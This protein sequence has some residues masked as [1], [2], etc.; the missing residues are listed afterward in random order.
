MDILDIWISPSIEITTFGIHQSLVSH[1]NGSQKTI[2][3]SS[4]PTWLS[5]KYKVSAS[6]PSPLT[7]D[8]FPLHSNI[9]ITFTTIEIPWSKLTLARKFNHFQ[10]VSICFKWSSY[11][12][13]LD[14]YAYLGGLWMGK[15]RLWHIYACSTYVILKIQSNTLSRTYMFMRSKS[16]R[17]IPWES[18]VIAEIPKWKNDS[19]KRLRDSRNSKVKE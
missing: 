10:A 5:S 9:V 16:E 17:M 3:L 11:P 7:M 1:Y 8:V 6:I 2:T 18:S 13:Y 4:P 15:S 12:S 14:S 19:M